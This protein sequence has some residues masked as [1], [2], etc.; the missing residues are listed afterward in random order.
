MKVL[1]ADDEPLVRYGLRSMVEELGLGLE[2]SA[3]AADGDAL[4]VLAL[5]HRPDV[6]FVDIRMPGLG[7]LAAIRKAKKAGLRTRWVI[8]TSHADFEYASEAIQLGVSAYLLKPAGPTQVAEVILPL[9]KDLEEEAADASARFEQSLVLALKSPGTSAPPDIPAAWVALV[10]LEAG[11]DA[12]PRDRTDFPSEAL[13]LVRGGSAVARTPALASA[14][15]SEG[16]DRIF[17]AARWSPDDTDA[18]AAAVRW[19]DG[20]GT[21]ARISA[22]LSLRMTVTAADDLAGWESLRSAVDRL[23]AAASLRIAAGSGTVHTLEGLIRRIGQ[24]SPAADLCRRAE[25]FL[26]ARDRG[27]YQELELRASGVQESF[28]PGVPSA[29]L[30]AVA[31]HLSFRTGLPLGDSLPRGAGWSAWAGGLVALAR[32]DAP[33]AR[34]DADVRTRIVERVDQYLRLHLA[35]EVRVPDL[36]SSLGLSPN[37]LSTVYRQATGATLSERLAGLRLDRARELLARPGSQ[38]KEVAA[39]VGYKGA[40]HFARLYHD[41]FGHY[42]SGR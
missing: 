12:S 11:A 9:M 31:R 33:D 34:R 37:Y 22:G 39:A 4:V 13:R 10:T 42:P 19:R 14:V 20:L 8:L 36:A 28:D 15:W 27:G 38:V 25:A 16:A 24:D 3:E 41:R 30:E 21:L 23:K 29:F 18:Q 32:A 6:A 35:D 1:I 40:R 7:G 26:E 2:V 17:A 5:K